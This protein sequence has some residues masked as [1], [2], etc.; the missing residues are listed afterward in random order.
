M[1][2]DT[3]KNDSGRLG[4]RDMLKSA[5]VASVA[6]MGLGNFTGRLYGS[7]GIPG[8]SPMS[9]RD[10]V[11]FKINPKGPLTI[12]PVFVYEI[13]ERVEGTS[14]RTWS[15]LITQEH[16]DTE[17][18]RIGNE[19][20]ALKT[21]ADFPLKILPLV[22]VRNSEEAKGVAAANHDGM[23]VYASGG[24]MYNVAPYQELLDPE[25]MNI[26]FLRHKSGPV[27]YY[28]CGASHR[29]LR[30]YTDDFQGIG[31]LQ[32]QDIVVD[33]H[34]E[35]LWRLRAFHGL[36]NTRGK[37]VVCIGGPGG[38]GAGSVSPENTR[39]LW[40]MEL[41]TVKYDRYNALIDSAYKDKN[42]VSQCAQKAA[43]Y[44]NQR[45][46][47][48]FPLQRELTTKELYAG[49]G[50]KEDLGPARTFLERAFVLEKVYIDLMEECDTNAIT[51]G[52][53]MGA[54]LNTSKTTA[55]MTLTLLN[56]NGYMAFCESDFAVI[57]ASILL[58]YISGKPVFFGNP[59]FPNNNIVTVAHCSAPRKMN[60]KTLEP[61]KIRTHFES[62]YGS[63]PKV[64]MRVGQ[65]ITVLV[66]DF[67][68]RRWAGFEGVIT[69]NPEMDICT[70]QI[71][72]QI[73]ADMDRLI[74]ETRGFH[75]PLCYGN[76]LRE[77]GYALGKTDI[78]WLN[79]T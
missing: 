60:G 52:G 10:P 37:K 71:N 16:V 40:G 72:I 79:I 44:L 68:S 30:Q 58:Y 63:A 75:W 51:V 17:I 6:T 73:N 31:N 9:G 47:S 33:D 5:L 3:K 53:C 34:N 28:Y 1:K 49:K 8:L 78:G 2:N 74:N 15:G 69:G 26:I 23:I 22:S 42:L 59:T 41:I 20:D 57:P 62:D 64:E 18:R 29:L 61:V 66:P 65:E 7:S 50:S 13:P 55:C 11:K 54:M 76:Y 43:D 46:V 27:Y 12:Q 24:P 25:K 21:R 67:L 56:D 32:P 77:V 39:M 4:R 38:Y 70:T 19:L 14:W 36:K 45:G 35:V 48:L